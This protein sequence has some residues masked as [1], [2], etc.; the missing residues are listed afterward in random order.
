[1]F[2]FGFVCSGMVS[3]IGV[4]VLVGSHQSHNTLVLLRR[5]LILLAFIL[6]RLVTVYRG[7]IHP[8]DAKEFR[9][10]A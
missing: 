10:H 9:A 2:I 1:M 5:R 8:I 6:S 7:Q 4:M 3:G